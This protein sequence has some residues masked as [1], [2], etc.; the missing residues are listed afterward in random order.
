MQQ[1]ISSTTLKER[2]TYIKKENLG[3]PNC[4]SS[5]SCCFLYYESTNEGKLLIVFWNAPRTV[6]CFAALAWFNYKQ[7]YLGLLRCTWY[8][9]I[10][11]KTND[12]D[13][14]GLK[15]IIWKGFWIKNWLVASAVQPLLTWA[16]I[17][18]LYIL[19]HILVLIQNKPKDY[20]RTLRPQ[21]KPTCPHP[22]LNPYWQY[23]WNQLEP[24]D[25][26]SLSADFCTITAVASRN[27]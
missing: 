27:N 20:I 7:S 24:H 6:W 14:T 18:C 11:R 10:S 26:G 21:R 17:T 4:Y 2:N 3:K 15:S 12:Y 5:R 1:K 23:R 13:P 25:F 8:F 22:M 19:D 16:Q 9:T